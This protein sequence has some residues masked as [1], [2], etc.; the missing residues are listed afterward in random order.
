M[1]P[2]IQASALFR[3]GNV[4]AV[5]VTA[6]ALAAVLHVFPVVFPLL[7]PL[8]LAVADGTRLRREIFVAHGRAGNGCKDLRDAVRDVPLRVPPRRGFLHA[9]HGTA[10]S[11]GSHDERAFVEEQTRRRDRVYAC[12]LIG[13]QQPS[14]CYSRGHSS[15]GRA[16]ESHSRGPGFESQW[17]HNLPLRIGLQRR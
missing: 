14:C 16:L 4:V 1:P 12:S 13:R 6:A 9:R 8:K 3:P 10:P 7:P 15:V 5:F 17:L 2:D 11:H